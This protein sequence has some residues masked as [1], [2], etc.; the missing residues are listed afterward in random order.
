MKFPPSPPFAELC[1]N[2]VSDFCTDTSP[3]VFEEAGC[4]LWEINYNL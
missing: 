1:Q 4:A 2:I 3:E